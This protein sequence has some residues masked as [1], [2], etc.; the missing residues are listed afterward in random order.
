MLV[1]FVQQSNVG[2][3]Q[4]SQP[5]QLNG[6]NWSLTYLLNEGL[7]DP[8]GTYSVTVQA[9]DNIG[10]RATPATTVVR[11]DTRGP[12]ATLNPN[13]VARQAISQPSQLEV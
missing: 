9:Q 10:N 13:D 2:M 1:K 7:Y 3:P 5:V 12:D 4:S 8:T 11:L 6:N